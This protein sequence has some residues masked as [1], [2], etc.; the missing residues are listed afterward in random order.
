[1]FS[2]H[3]KGQMYISHFKISFEINMSFFLDIKQFQNSWVYY[4]FFN[5]TLC[6]LYIPQKI[7]VPFRIM[8]YYRTPCILVNIKKNVE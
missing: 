7:Y 6:F 4:F 3:A 8:R 2:N 5:F 1:M